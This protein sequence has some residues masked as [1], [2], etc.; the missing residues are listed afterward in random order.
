MKIAISVP[1]PLFEAAEKLAKVRCIPRSKLYS[2][3]LS[4]YVSS[5]SSDEVTAQLNKVYSSAESSL[6]P[7]FASFQLEAI[8]DESW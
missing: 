2:E 3:A 4:F 6:E 7:E 8:G 5:Q 1:D